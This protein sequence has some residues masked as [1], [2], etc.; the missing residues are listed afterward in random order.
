MAP[1][2]W[3][4][5]VL[6]ARAI[7]L[8]D[9]LADRLAVRSENGEE[10]AES[11]VRL[12]GVA[13]L[14]DDFL[15]P[16]GR[17]HIVAMVGR[18]GVARRDGGRGVLVAQGT[19]FGLEFLGLVDRGLPVAEGQRQAPLEVR[20]GRVGPLALGFASHPSRLDFPT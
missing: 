19:D 14:L 3:V 4:G 12:A 5:R 8:S 20:P 15:D 6:P 17:D 7:D 1:V 11:F 10:R 18:R 9:V 16:V 2:P 13:E